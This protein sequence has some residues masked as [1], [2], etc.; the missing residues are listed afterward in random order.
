M[1]KLII[2]TLAVA[3]TLAAVSA[4]HAGYWVW[5][6]FMWVYQPVCNIYGCF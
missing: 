6:G 2:S 1:R 5:N 4:A 3:S